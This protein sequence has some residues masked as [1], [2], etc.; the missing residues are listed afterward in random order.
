MTQSKQQTKTIFEKGSYA[1][2]SY[3]SADKSHLVFYIPELKCASCLWLVQKTLSQIQD[4][5]KVEINLAQR[6]A[7]IGFSHQRPNLTTITQAL[8]RIGYRSFPAAERLNPDAN[9]EISRTRLKQ[10]AVAGV[11]FANVMLFSA[12]LYF[13][14]G[15]DIDLG[16]QKFF[17]WASFAITLGSIWMTARSLF[18]NAWFALVYK[19]LHVDLPILFAMLVALGASAWN[20]FHG[21]SDVYFDSITGLLF[22]L[23]VGRTLHDSLLERAKQLTKAAPS[24]LP[25]RASEVFPNEVIAI[26]PG[27][28]FPADGVVESGVSEVNE[29]LLTGESFLVAKRKSDKVY[30][31]TQNIMGAMQMKVVA[32]QQDTRLWQILQAIEGAAQ[33]KVIYQ[34]LI[35]KILPWFVLAT[36]GFASLGFFLWQSTNIVFAVKVFVTVLIVCCPC[37]LALAMPLASTFYLR[38][39]WQHGALVKSPDA[40]ER[41]AKVNTIVL[42]KTRTITTGEIEVTGLLG[43]LTDNLTTR[44]RV[45]T[46]ANRH[47]VSKA[48]STY[49]KPSRGD[50]IAVEVAEFPAGGAKAAFLD[51]EKCWIGQGE[52]LSAQLIAAGYTDCAFK[53]RDLMSPS[54]CDCVFACDGHSVCAFLLHDP[55]RP[56]AK[57]VFESWRKQNISVFIAS[58]DTQARVSSVAAELSIPPQNAK[59]LLNPEEKLDVVKMLAA[60]KHVVLFV[61]DGMNDAAAASGAHVSIAV[62]GSIDI[63]VASSDVAL[64]RPSLENIEA[65]LQFSRYSV[66]TFRLLLGASASYNLVAV[67]LAYVGVLH[68]LVAA[69]IMPTASITILLL[70]LFRK[71]DH[72]W[73]SSFL[74][75]PS[76]LPSPA[77]LPSSFGGQ[78]AQGNGTT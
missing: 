75:S 59:G 53:L 3:L 28:I 37:A 76:R 42:D 52:W 43:T 64:D 24:A 50:P 71:G 8:T 39:A 23:L 2:E 77:S 31:G 19:K 4:V 62:G 25:P 45:L 7:T 5:E 63:A 20:L 41:L 35:D 44:L 68:P 21:S 17:L 57:Q 36:L 14:K 22:F 65:L 6:C 74:L 69:L 73:P 54:A 46:K 33:N 32:C 13:A 9:K 1:I 58:G 15:Q 70:C 72:L 34:N 30:A 51:G 55:I 60:S 18:R 11:A 49:L 47:P 16:I 26:A 38:R 27:E 29:S 61:G 78:Q 67:M 12:A 48:V 10:L 40:L 66:S 56:E